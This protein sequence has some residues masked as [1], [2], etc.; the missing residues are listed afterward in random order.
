MMGFEP[1]PHCAIFAPIESFRLVVFLKAAGLAPFQL[2]VLS[3][4]AGAPACCRAEVRFDGCWPEG[5]ALAGRG[6]ISR[7]EFVESMVLIDSDNDS[8]SKTGR[9]RKVSAAELRSQGIVCR[10]MV[11]FVLITLRRLRQCHE[12][13]SIEAESRVE[14]MYSVLC[15]NACCSLEAVGDTEHPRHQGTGRRGVA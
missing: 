7:G 10:S 12:V 14:A 2:F 11:C 13:M 8:N 5:E 9:A 4:P 15:N 1:L 3:M 6:E